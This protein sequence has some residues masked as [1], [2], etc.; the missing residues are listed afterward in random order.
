MG[1][2]MVQKLLRRPPL[3][4]CIQSIGV[5]C[6]TGCV[7]PVP[8]DLSDPDAGAKNA[9]P[10]I[11][12]TNPAMPGPLSLVST[13]EVSV[14]LRDADLRDTLYVRV[15]RNYLT[16]DTAP[17]H[18]YTV[19]NDPMNGQETRSPLRI[20]TGAWCVPATTFA[21]TQIIIDIAV[22]DRKFSADVNASPQFLA[23]DDKVGKVNIRSWVATCP[24]GQ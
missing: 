21:G 12:E 7:I 20:D 14:T 8:A 4:T 23:L 11:E 17:L 15:F 3:A 9:D 6:L 19:V 18:E 2:K 13:Q 5:A 1:C 24:V 22:A 10:V 16:G